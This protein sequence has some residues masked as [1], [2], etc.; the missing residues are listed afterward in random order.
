MKSKEE[1]LASIKPNMRLTKS[2]FLKIYGYQLYEPEFKEICLRKLKEAGCLKAE[3]YYEMVVSEYERSYEKEKKEVATWYRKW[4]EKEGEKKKIWKR[5][6]T[7]EYLQ[8]KS[9]KELLNLLQELNKN[10]G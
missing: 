6:Q 2:F 1:L 9:D 3:E 5:T 10:F 4:K 7:V 8:K